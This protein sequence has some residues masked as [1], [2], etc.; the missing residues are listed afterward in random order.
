MDQ[1]LMEG[2]Y[3]HFVGKVREWLGNVVENDIEVDLWRRDQ[4]VGRV[5]E[6]CRVPLEEEEALATEAP[7]LIVA[8]DPT[9]DRKDRCRTVSN[10]TAS[11]Q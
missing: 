9:F 3:Y 10:N 5:A 2:R 11:T 8:E 6:H 1:P 4:L 7:G